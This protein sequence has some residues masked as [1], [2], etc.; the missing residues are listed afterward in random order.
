MSI[1]ESDLNR[2]SNNFDFIRLLASLFVLIGHSAPILSNKVIGWDPCDKLVGIPIHFLG[3]LIFF[4]LSGFLVTHSW[5]SKRNLFDFFTARVLRIFPALIVVV[6]LSVFVLGICIT[7]DTIPDYLSAKTTL[8]YLENITLYRIYYD[9]PGVFETNPIG[10]GVNGSLWT[11]PHEF[12]CYLFLMI[13]GSLMLLKNKWIYLLFLVL[14]TIFYL[15]FETRID[16]TILPILEIDLESF[17]TLFLYF[18]SGSVYYHFR[19]KIS[20]RVGGLVLCGALEILIRLNYLPRLMNVF[21]LP[22]FIFFLAF[23]KTIKLYQTG[24]YGDFSY[25][26]YLYAYPIQQII[27]YLLPAKLNLWAMIIFSILLTAPF[28]V[29]SWKFIESPAL[30]LR[31]RVKIFGG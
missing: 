14:L 10:S 24:K 3:V 29:L 13:M 7:K 11:L 28:A 16:A 4:T 17:F 2:S 30:K 26:M 27:V 1:G 21:V 23:S 25:G 8:K 5:Y 18:I 22:Y 9:L 12:T 19:K 15:L 31:Q 6:L 20:F